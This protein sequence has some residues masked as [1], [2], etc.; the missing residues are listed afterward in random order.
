MSLEAVGRFV[1]TPMPE[2]V[3]VAECPITDSFWH[4]NARLFAASLD[5]EEALESVLNWVIE[6]EA[7]TGKPLGDGLGYR[8]KMQKPVVIEKVRAA[9]AKARAREVR[10]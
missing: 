4:E 2:G 9:L 8:A 6:A 7:E 1:R 5:M 3:I 10:L